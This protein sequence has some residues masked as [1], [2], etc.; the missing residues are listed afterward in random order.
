MLAIPIYMSIVSIEKWKYLCYLCSLSSRIFSSKK[1]MYQ[2]DKMCCLLL[3]TCCQ[4]NSICSSMCMSSWQQS[5]CSNHT[6]APESTTHWFPLLY[7]C[8]SLHELTCYRSLK[9]LWYLRRRLQHPVE[10]ITQSQEQ[11]S[12]RQ[13]GMMTGHAAATLLCHTSA[14]Q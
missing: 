1:R 7:L 9:G 2:P 13:Q 11:Y 3:N 14:T 10:A 12:Y 8:V 4:L 5:C 6:L